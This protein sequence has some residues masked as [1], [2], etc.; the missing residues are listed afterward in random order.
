MS[1]YNAH[2]IRYLTPMFFITSVYAAKCGFPILSFAE[3][4]VGFS[5]LY[6]WSNYS[7]NFRRTVDIVIVQISLYIHIYFSIRYK[8]TKSLYCF[9]LLAI[10]YFI[11]RAYDSIAAHVLVWIFG[12]LGA[13]I[14]INHLCEINKNKDICL[15]NNIC[16]K[17]LI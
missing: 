2:W 7:C 14:L 8:S 11:G 1:D 4:M 17:K 12:T 16:K 3:W 9:G 15:T 6:Y 5:S 13:I 10:F